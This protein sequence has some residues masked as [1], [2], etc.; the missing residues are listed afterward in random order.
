MVDGVLVIDKPRDLTS[1]DVVAV[2]RRALGERRI[3]HTGTLDPLASGVVAADA[4]LEI[5]HRAGHLERLACVADRALPIREP[6]V[7]AVRARELL[8]GRP[9]SRRGLL[10]LV[11]QLETLRLGGRD[12]GGNPLGGRAMDAEVRAEP[13]QP[14]DLFPSPPP[15]PATGS[16]AESA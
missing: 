3:G 11:D 10:V 2:A 12:R 1:H 9:L 16:A 14:L 6:P 15:P 8:L 7:L 4:V 13:L 5:G